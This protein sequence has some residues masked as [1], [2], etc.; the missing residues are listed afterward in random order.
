MKNGQSPLRLANKYLCFCFAT[1]RWLTFS[2]RATPQCKNDIILTEFAQ[3]LEI[4]YFRFHTRQ[5]YSF[6][7]KLM[8]SIHVR[9]PK[10]V[11]GE[12]KGPFRLQKESH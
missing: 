8:D 10:N 3:A 12:A 1:T 5:N 6:W 7:T 4:C 9:R 11:G 2:K